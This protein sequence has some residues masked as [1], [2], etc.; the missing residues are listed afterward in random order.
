M[1]F[2]LFFVLLELIYGSTAFAQTDQYETIG[3]KQGLIFDRHQTLPT[4]H[5]IAEHEYGIKDGLADMT[6]NKVLMDKVGRLHIETEGGGATAFGKWYSEFDGT[7]SYLPQLK[8]SNQDYS[9]FHLEGKDATGR[10]FGYV[11]YQQKDKDVHSVFV[12]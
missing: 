9:L 3:I 5:P 10:L 4:F 7:R 6:M 11:H 1:R 12:V 8:L 2:L